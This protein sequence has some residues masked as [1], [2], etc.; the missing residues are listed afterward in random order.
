MLALADKDNETGDTTLITK[1]RQ[2]TGL[3]NQGATCYMNSLLQTLYLT[4]EFRAS[5]L[6][7]FI[8]NE[9]LHG[10]ESDCI[11]FQL[12]KLFGMLYLSGRDC[13]D[14]RDLTKSFQWDRCQSFQ[15]HDVQEFCRVLFDAIE[16]SSEEHTAQDDTHTHTHTHTHTKQFQSNFRRYTKPVSGTKSLL[17]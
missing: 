1:E 3:T 16:A 14:T 8:Y 13:V 17:Y 4:P 12:Q 9:K 11:P 6:Q 15:Q 5:L 7:K 10:H 2:H